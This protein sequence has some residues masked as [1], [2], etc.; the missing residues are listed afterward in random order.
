MVADWLSLD[1]GYNGPDIAWRSLG[2]KTTTKG[3][4]RQQSGAK[5]RDNCL[6]PHYYKLCKARSILV[7]V[8]TSHQRPRHIYADAFQI[9]V[10]LLDLVAVSFVR[11]E[12]GI[13]TEYA[14]RT[15]G[16]EAQG[17]R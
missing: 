5:I 13:P 3:H 11:I 15:V 2:L 4:K 16:A 6:D 10:A 17:G 8:Q 14:A 12:R 7:E 9:D 1:S